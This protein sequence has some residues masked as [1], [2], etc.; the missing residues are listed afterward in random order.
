MPIRRICLQPAQNEDAYNVTIDIFVTDEGFATR[1]MVALGVLG[2]LRE[3]AECV[4]PFLLRPDGAMDF[5]TVYDEDNDRDG[6]IERM[7]ER[8]F[9]VGELFTISYEG[10]E[11]VYRVAQVVD[12][13]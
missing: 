6:R 5:G 12:H 3:D 11:Y 7:A 2:G 13:R 9:V 10:E 8:P 4:E 1:Q